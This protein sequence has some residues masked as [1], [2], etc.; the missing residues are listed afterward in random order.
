MQRNELHDVLANGEANTKQ[1]ALKFMR[2]YHFESIEAVP[3]LTLCPG[4]KY[5]L[6]W[7]CEVFENRESITFLQ[8]PSLHLVAGKRAT[9]LSVTLDNITE[10]VHHNTAGI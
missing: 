4:V 1:K 10:V 6:H 5:F 3:S 7:V 9:T 8:M 2:Q